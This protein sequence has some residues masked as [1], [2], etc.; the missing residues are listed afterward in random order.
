MKYSEDSNR[1]KIKVCG[2][3]EAENIR[4]LEILHPDYIGFIFYPASK[5][6]AGRYAAEAAVKLNEK[7]K[8]TGVFVNA[9]AEE[10]AKK[11]DAYG[12]NAIQLHGSEDA[13]F[14]SQM[15]NS[16]V[17]V[18]KAFGIDEDFNFNSLKAYT[19]AVDFFLFD[20]KTNAYGGSGQ[21]FNW[22][23]LKKY[24]LGKPYFLSGGL[25]LDNLREIKNIQD[26]RLYALDLNS[27]FETAPGLK[28]IEKLKEAFS[29]I[30]S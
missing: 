25:S 11:I 30:N 23:Y 15:K 19:N 13:V 17:E 24:T 29:I 14:C 4:Q 28:D 22:D 6:Y 21:T 18:I 2:M 10:I 12:L 26:G 27:R 5:R 9:S 16:G 1:L 8:K 7:I 20:T 3:R